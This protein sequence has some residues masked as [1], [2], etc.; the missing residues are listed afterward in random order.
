MARELLPCQ[1]VSIIVHQMLKKM[2]QKTLRDQTR[3]KTAALYMAVKEKCH[4]WKFWHPC[5]KG[6]GGIPGTRPNTS[7]CRS[8]PNQQPQAAKGH[9]VQVAQQ[10]WAV[11]WTPTSLHA[12]PRAP[13]SMQ[14]HSNGRMPPIRPFGGGGGGSPVVLIFRGTQGKKISGLN[15]LAPVKNCDR[16]KARKK[17]AQSFK[18]GEWGDPPTPQWC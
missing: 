2:P 10:R 3:R 16:P 18:G 12:E 4:S 9:N 6:A 14:H 13:P 8:S 11:V 7:D 17:L 1:F 5:K 15:K